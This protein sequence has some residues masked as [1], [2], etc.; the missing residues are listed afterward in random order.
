MSFES[1]LAFPGE[2][3][4]R[5][6]MDLSTGTAGILL[7]LGAALH[8]EPVGLPFLTVTEPAAQASDLVLAT[9]NGG[10]RTGR[11]LELQRSD[12]GRKQDVRN[13]IPIPTA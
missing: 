7:A 3:L 1:E 6:S 9:T 8:D 2:E 12:H 5:M 13:D 10:K 11:K 4:L